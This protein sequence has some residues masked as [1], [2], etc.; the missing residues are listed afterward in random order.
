MKSCIKKLLPALFFLPFVL[1][2]IGYL[3]GGEAPTDALY[4]SFLLYLSN[5]ASDVYN[6]W[7]EVARWT[8]PLVTATALL[9]VLGSLGRDLWDRLRCLT[10]DSVA[11]YG[12]QP[13]T[14]TF[15]PQTRVLYPGQRYKGYARTHILLFSS[16][17]QS[18]A[19]WARHRQ[20]LQ[21]KPVYIGLRE[22]D[23]GLL[24]E[25]QGAFVFDVGNT[26]ARLLWKKIRL[27]ESPQPQ[28]Q[29]VIYG[30]GPLSQQILSTGLM[31]NLFS[32][33]Q[34][35]T[36]HLVGEQNT[37]CWKHPDLPLDNGDRLVFHRALTDEVWAL[38][39]QADLVIVA[40]ELPADLLQVFAVNAAGRPLYLYAPTEG[41]AG[42]FLAYGRPVLFGQ[43]AEILTDEAI[44]RQQTVKKAAELNRRYAE[45]YQ[46]EADWNRL[47]GF[48]KNSNISS[49]DFLEVVAELPPDTPEE[50]LAELEHIRW[51]RFHRLNYWKPGN[52]AKGNKDVERRIHRDLVP[53]AL[54]PESEKE[55]DRAVIRQARQARLCG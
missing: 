29:I 39:R 15:G 52:P 33:A 54:L 12:D 24:A 3:L 1:G 47:S 9:S 17:R 28:Q 37:F 32:T 14:V 38:V 21:G 41:Q 48:L 16:D 40:E 23:T 49:A 30:N 22:L 25:Q 31:M 18:L 44:R 55:K 50:E 45:A 2:A 34:Q 43:A 11:V 7:V 10:G 4:A 42:E 36:Y 19:F 13:V 6:G 46:G 5:P 53:Y 51:C 26:I 20:Q 35:L 8:A 27:W